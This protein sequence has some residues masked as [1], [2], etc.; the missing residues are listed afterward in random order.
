MMIIGS[1]PGF[2]V[3][4][5]WAGEL[6]ASGLAG[7]LLTAC[8]VCLCLGTSSYLRGQSADPNARYQSV[9]IDAQAP[10]HSFPHFWER[11]FGSGRAIL[12]LHASYREDLRAVKRATDFEYMRFHAILDDEVGLYN[13]APGVKP[14][15]NFSYVD[16]IYD[17]LLANGV[18]PYVELSFMPKALASTPKQQAFWY[19]PYVAPPKDW[20]LW[21]DLIRHFASR[22]IARYGIEEVSQWYFEVWNEPNLDFWAGEPRQATYFTLYDRTAQALKSV[23]PRIRV[24]GPATAQAA[25]VSEFIRHCVDTNAPLDFVSTHV[26]GNDTAED[27]LG[28]HEQ[29]S[30]LEMVIRAVKKVHEEV[31]ASPRPD[32]PIVFSEY[33]ASYMNEPDVTDSA[34]MGPWLAY[35][36]QPLRWPGGHA[37]VLEFLRRL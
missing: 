37:R 20:S 22:L 31:K 6:L 30:R 8:T 4:E 16:Q 12:S 2:P 28:T 35:T 24:G 18:R 17:G 26:Y 13:A 14:S 36:D 9:I 1:I 11:A 21:Q 33:N 19:H 15:Y 27:V 5:R 29:V 32:L 25:W 10:A 23:S 7:R 34:F 3:I